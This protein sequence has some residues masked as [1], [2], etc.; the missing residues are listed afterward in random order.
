MIAESPDF[1]RGEYVN[2]VSG[3]QTGFT[4]GS[5]NVQIDPTNATVTFKDGT[6]KFSNG[7]ASLVIDVQSSS[8]D[9]AE[10]AD[11]FDDRNF[12]DGTT[13]DD[14]TPITYEQGEYQ[15]IYAATNFTSQETI[16]AAFAE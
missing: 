16:T 15:N 2:K 12:V 9:L 14:I 7:V 5:D 8:A 6:L 3:F 4:G 1:S 13:L 10:S 11:L